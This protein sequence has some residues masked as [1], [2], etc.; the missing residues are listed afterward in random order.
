MLKKER[1]GRGLAPWSLVTWTLAALVVIT[2]YAIAGTPAKTTRFD[3]VSLRTFP[4]EAAPLPRGD[5]WRPAV[6]DL[7]R[8]YGAR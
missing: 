3:E 4:H 2:S 7:E 5:R 6:V 1:R 8:L